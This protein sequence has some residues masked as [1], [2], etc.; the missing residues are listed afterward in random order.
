MPYKKGVIF[1]CASR[2]KSVRWAGY[3]VLDAVKTLF[4]AIR[5]R[6][7]SADFLY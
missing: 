4:E 1:D 7:T 6:I 3:S 2:A 5:R